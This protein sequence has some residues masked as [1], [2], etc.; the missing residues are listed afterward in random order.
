MTQAGGLEELVLNL[1]PSS[2]I[3]LPFFCYI[4]RDVTF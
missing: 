1:L 2:H 4:V 3:L